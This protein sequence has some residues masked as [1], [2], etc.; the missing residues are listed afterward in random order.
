MWQTGEVQ[1]HTEPSWCATCQVLHSH[2]QDYCWWHRVGPPADWCDIHL[3][4]DLGPD[5]CFRWDDLSVI[6][7]V[8]VRI[9]YIDHSSCGGTETISCRSVHLFIFFSFFFGN[10]VMFVCVFVCVF[11]HIWSVCVC[12]CVCV[13]MCEYVCV[14]LLLHSILEMFVFTIKQYGCK[15]WTHEEAL[16]NCVNYGKLVQVCLKLVWNVRS[17][18]AVQVCASSRLWMR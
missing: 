11:M 17:V 4:A 15:M 9:D 2:W 12:V 6:V 13:C 5:D 1:D 16:H 14:Y 8:F 10:F 18:F 3:P 7:L